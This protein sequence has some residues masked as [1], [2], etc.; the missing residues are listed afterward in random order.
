MAVRR[1]SNWLPRASTCNWIGPSLGRANPFGW[2]ENRQSAV[3]SSTS[4]RLPVA[5]MTASR[6]AP[7]WSS[8]RAAGGLG[9]LNVN[10]A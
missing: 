9:T 6:R 8:L 3:Y 5:A 10:C 2:T 4:P 1:N 7:T